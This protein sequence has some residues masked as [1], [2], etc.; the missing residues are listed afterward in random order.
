MRVSWTTASTG[1]ALH[2]SFSFK[3][4]LLALEPHKH[5]RVTLRSLLAAARCLARLQYG[6][7]DSGEWIGCAAPG[8]TGQANSHLSASP[9]ST[10]DTYSVRTGD[11]LL[12]WASL[13]EQGLCMHH[14]GLDA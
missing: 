7:A 8:C 1:C 9:S 12:G 14:C 6:R 10:V 3:M 5:C 11:T 4:Y 2:F 13:P